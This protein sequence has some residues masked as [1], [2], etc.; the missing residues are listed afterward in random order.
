MTQ[1][2]GSRSQNMSIGYGPRGARPIYRW[3]ATAGP[4]A[5]TT[6][7]PGAA[8]T[9]VG[10]TTASLNGE[11]AGHASRVAAQRRRW[12]EPRAASPSGSLA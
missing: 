10:L 9:L 7:E 5:I 2:N 12:T 1:S 8:V 3:S 4:D 6:L 11:G